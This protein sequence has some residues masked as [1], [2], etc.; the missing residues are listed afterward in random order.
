M[1]ILAGDIGGTNTRLWLVETNGV[2]YKAVKPKTFYK[3]REAGENGLVSLVKDFLGSD[4]SVDKACFAVAG[5][6]L[7]DSCKITNLSWPVLTSHNLQQDLGIA[8]VGLINDF[9]AV[10][11]SLVFEKNKSLLTLQE[12]DYSPNAPIAII[13]AGT[14]L[15]KAFAVPQ[16][17]SYRVFPTEGGH[18]NFAPYDRLTQKL[19]KDLSQDGSEL[20]DVE[21]PVSGRGIAEIFTFLASSEF[22]ELDPG[23]FLAQEDPSQAISRG[24]AGGNFLCQQTMNLFA[25][26]FGAAAGDMGVNL[27]P[28]GGLYIAGGVAPKN[29]EFLNDGRFIQAFRRKAKLNPELLQKIPVHIYLNDLEGLN[30]A[31]N[32]AI[33]HM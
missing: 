6:V 18:A 4:Y 21:T 1:L 32:Y 28:F 20:V 33:H 7:N 11:Y 12:G 31:V 27:L 29:I 5:P 2:T 25:E 14:G 9:V 13:G 16:G 10:G 8:Q 26:I 22:P 23:N 17:D 30:G 15:G 3:S 24:A 19:L